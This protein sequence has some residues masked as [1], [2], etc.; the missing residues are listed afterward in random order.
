MEK[1]PTTT[2]KTKYNRASAIVKRT[3]ITAKRNRW[4]DICTNLDLRRD[5]K[6]AWA[7][8]ENLSGTKRKSNPTIIPDC[9][10]PF[11]RAEKFNK[12]FASI[13]KSRTDKAMDEPLLK[14]LKVHEKN[15]ESKH[16]VFE[17]LFTLQEL[18]QAVKK[19]K[20]S[21]SPGPDKIHNEMLKHLGP[22]GKDTLLSLINLTWREG[23]LPQMWKNAIITPILKKARSQ[24]I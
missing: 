23:Q 20:N 1:E 10:T 8:L 4:R 5:G 24:R 18:E 19:L 15:K 16:T 21:K 9:E 3:T 2:N 13:N 6:K 11:K 14:E 17:D 12:H 22:W 7:L